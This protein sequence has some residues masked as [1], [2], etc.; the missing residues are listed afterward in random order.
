MIETPEQNVFISHAS[1]DKRKYI[2]PLTEA[3]VRRQVT[4]WLD[5]VK[6]EW[7]DSVV[8]K[9]N[10]GL[11]TSQY[12]L[13]CLSQ[14]FLQ[15]PW[16]EAEMGAV[17]SLQNSSGGKRVLPLILNS[18]DAVL[19]HYPLIAG[20]AY[21]EF[22]DA[23]EVASDIAKLTRSSQTGSEELLVTVEG[24][25]TGKLC[26]LKAPKR[27]SIQWLAKMAQAGLDVDESFKV[28][29]FSEFRVRWV[30]V[31]VEVED[32]WLKMSRR[33]QRLAHALVADDRGCKIAGSSRDKLED[34]GVKDGT[35][36][37][38]YAIEDEDFP[39]PPAAPPPHDLDNG[40]VR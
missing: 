34:V 20:L 19:L 26:R 39:P 11:R 14:A 33:R 5:D 31:D 25:H 21:R 22:H 37:H 15:R 13:L 18:K 2:Y 40:L 38:L 12:A 17:L 27:A 9:V 30:L 28:G 10:Q 1:A 4:F 24:V 7:G 3:L 16:P 23:D 32:S 8:G 36:F 6:I 29:P 35:V